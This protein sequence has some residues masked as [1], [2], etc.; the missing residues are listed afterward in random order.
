M[1][2]KA[3]MR[4]FSRFSIQTA[5]RTAYQMLVDRDKRAMYAGF[6]Y[7]N[8]KIMMLFA[9]SAEKVA[10]LRQVANLDTVEILDTIPVET[11]GING[12]LNDTEQGVLSMGVRCAMKTMKRNKRNMLVCEFSEPVVEPMLLV[13]AR[14]DVV[15]EIVE[16]AY[17]TGLLEQPD[18]QAA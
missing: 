7:K 15:D 2:A 13:Y 5:A 14:G 1:A 12:Q 9:R 18:A 11:Q 6:D 3:K 16:R 10:L 4:W 8:D 17:A